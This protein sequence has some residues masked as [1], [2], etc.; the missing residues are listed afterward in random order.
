MRFG[1]HHV[2]L[3]YFLIIT[4]ADFIGD[5]MSSKSSNEE[6][7]SSLDSNLDGTIEEFEIQQVVSEFGGGSLDEPEEIKRRFLIDFE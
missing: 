1:S 3:L 4:R 6:F 7:F 5:G 2:F